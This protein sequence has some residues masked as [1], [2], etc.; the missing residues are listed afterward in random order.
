MSPI[1]VNIPV[2]EGNEAKYVLEAVETGWISSEGPFVKEFETKFAERNGRKH[3]IAVCNGTAALQVAIDT[4]DLEPEDE[5]I[6]PTFTIIACVN[7]VIRAGAKPVLVDCDPETF[8]STPEQIESAITEK[9]KAIMLVHIYGLPVDADPILQMAEKRG[10]KVIEDAAEVI[11]LDYKDRPCGSLGD[12]S[13]VSFYP[14]KHITTGEGGMVLTDDD[15]LADQCRSLRDHCFQAKKRFY[16]ERIGWNFRMT[17]LQAAI[18]LAQLE[19]LDEFVVKKRSMGQSYT[20]LLSECP[21]LQL[22]IA[23]TPYAQNIYWVY[24]IVLRDEFPLDAQSV[25]AKLGEHKI[26]TR[27]FFYPMH[28]QP[29]YHEMGYFRD[30]VHPNAERLAERG[31]YVPGGLSLTEE[32]ISTVSEKLIEIVNV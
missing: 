19:R 9:T 5:V 6:V 15:D 30:D 31:F 2:L 21:N 23:Q 3:G 25:M 24:G 16:H 11:G 4:L 17:N 1:P 18:G 13:I 12:L 26:G 7:A 32:E 10:I 14:N 28:K 8:N 27:P 22:P 29:I 20:K